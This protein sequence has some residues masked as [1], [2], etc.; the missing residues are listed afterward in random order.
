[1]SVRS[2]VHAGTSIHTGAGWQQSSGA[3]RA[4]PKGIDEAG[5]SAATTPITAAGRAQS[6][7]LAVT[8]DLEL[9]EMVGTG[10]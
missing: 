4:L 2:V 7:P 10:G 1:M 8:D 3:P 6:G 9:E 5:R